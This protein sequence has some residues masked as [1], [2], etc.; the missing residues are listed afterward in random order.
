MNRVRIQVEGPGELVGIET[1]GDLGIALG[2]G[3]EI[4]SLVRSLSGNPLD[5]AVGRIAG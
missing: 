2:D 4:D 3:A 1:V 5:D